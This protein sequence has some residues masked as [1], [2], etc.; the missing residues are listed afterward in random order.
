MESLE[1]PPL[2][3]DPPEADEYEVEGVSVFHLHDP[4][5]PLADVQLRIVG[6]VSHFSREELAVVSA[7]PSILRAGGTRDLSPDSINRRVD[8]LALELSFSGSGQAT[9]IGMNSL[10]QT[11]EPALELLRDILV[12]P[13]FDSDALEVWRGQASDRIRRR[14]DNPTNLAFSE[15]NRLM[16]GDHPGGWVMTEEDLSLDRLSVDRL[17]TVHEALFCTDRLILGVS[18]DLSWEEA[19]PLIRRFL[20]PWPECDRELSEPPTPTIRQDAGLFILQKEIDQSTV[21]MAETA[22]VRQEDSSEYFSAQIANHVL[23]AGG[24]TSRILSSVRTE[25][26]LAY[27]ASSIWTTPVRYDGL[28]GALTATAAGTT[29]EATELL[30]SVLQDL[31]DSPP[32]AT[33]VRHAIEEITNGYVFA[34]ESP[35]RIV[36]RQMLAAA[37]GLPDRWLSRYVEGLQEVTPRDVEDVVAEH[38]NPSRLTI[39]LVGDPRRFDPGLNAFG[40]VY[41][42]FPDGTYEPWVSPPDA[43]SGSPRSPR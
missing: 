29:L 42:L 35:S 24:F 1:F 10:T 3:F 21:I 12:E 41:E 22:G 31:R 9:S 16:Y 18:G 8:L 11:L 32:S 39:L 40:P 23:G 5:L 15:F 14:E 20:G 4:T 30:I 26:G 19:E 7:L 38:V 37:E 13:G 33:E 6:G 36:S 2:A 43:P 28:V 27:G 25:E 34:F 17:R